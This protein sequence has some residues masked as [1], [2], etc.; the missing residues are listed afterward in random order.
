MT[1][2]YVLKKPFKLF[3]GPKL[4]LIIDKLKCKKLRELVIPVGFARYLDPYT[5]LA[6]TYEKN[7]TNPAF[8]CV[9]YNG[10]NPRSF[11]LDDFA[12]IRT[13]HRLARCFFVRYRAKR[14]MQKRLLDLN[15]SILFS[16]LRFRY[17]Y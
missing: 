15:S 17:I 13:C 5:Y 11:M 16:I 6:A 7:L 10:L 12:I 2:G 4:L 9:E 14:Q 3:Y 8:I 1:Y